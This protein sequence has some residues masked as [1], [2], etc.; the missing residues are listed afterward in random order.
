[1]V[2]ITKPVQ[3]GGLYYAPPDVA[4]FTPEV[5]ALLLRQGVATRAPEASDVPNPLGRGKS[6]APEPR[7][8]AIDALADS[9]GVG[10]V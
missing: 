8:D 1:M 6:R 9:Q 4:R 7:F 10:A 2:A 3:V 5:E